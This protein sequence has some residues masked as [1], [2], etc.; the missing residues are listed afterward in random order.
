MSLV[1]SGSSGAL[2]VCQAAQR[3]EISEEEQQKRIEDA[4]KLEEK[5]NYIQNEV[6][7]R[8][9][10]VSGSTAGAGSGDFHQY[11]TARRREQ[12]RV[13]RI[14]QVEWQLDIYL[15]VAASSCSHPRASAINQRL[16]RTG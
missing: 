3:P 4:N 5:L 2:V 7:T 15:W 1:P 14:E 10:N 6:A 8:I 13:A 16:K 9:Y 12:F 11:R